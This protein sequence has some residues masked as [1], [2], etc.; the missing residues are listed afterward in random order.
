MELIKYL[1]TH[2]EAAALYTQTRLGTGIGRNFASE[3]N[4]LTAQKKNFAIT[5]AQIEAIDQQIAAIKKQQQD[6]YAGLG[7][8]GL[9]GAATPG[10]IPPPP[11]GASIIQ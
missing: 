6:F 4:A 8:S 11:D 7:V 2:P 10:A 5:S 1:T 3:I 9:G